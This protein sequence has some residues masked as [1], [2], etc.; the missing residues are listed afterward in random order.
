M[1]M[2]DRLRQA[3]IAAGYDHAATAAEA[4]G[5]PYGTYSGHENGLR[6]IP[7]DRVVF[8]ARKFRVSPQ[9][10]LTGEGSPRHLTVPI[11]GKVSADPNATVHFGD[12]QGQLGETLVPPGADEKTVAVEVEGESMHGVA[13]PGALVYYNDRHDP[14]TEDLIGLTC[15]VGLDD[16]RVMIKKLLRG[17]KPKHF[18]LYSISAPLMQD[19]RVIWAAPIMAVIHPFYAKDFIIHR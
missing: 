16:G 13:E 5:I 17:R 7:K 9:W 2:H 12:G 6:G 15:I 11:V 4:L 1:E 14:P 19:A 10:L 8:Y 18:D 3:R